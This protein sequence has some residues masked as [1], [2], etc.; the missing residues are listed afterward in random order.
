MD[1]RTTVIA[2]FR[3]K[4]ETVEKLVQIILILVQETRTEKGCL[5]Y[6][7]YRDLTDST[8]FYMHENWQS[9]ADLEAHFKTAHVKAAFEILPPLLTEPVEIRR[10][11]MINPN[12]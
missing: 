9:A 2:R 10:L 1:E 6:D 12:A 4:P 8:L 5:N 7:F 3:A 11:Q